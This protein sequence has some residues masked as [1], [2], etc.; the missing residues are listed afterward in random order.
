MPK[1]FLTVTVQHNQNRLTFDFKSLRQLFPNFARRMNPD[2]SCIIAKIF[3]DPIHDGFRCEAEHSIVVEELQN[4]GSPCCHN[5]VKSSH[6]IDFRWFCSQK[7]KPTDDQCHSGS[8]QVPVLLKECH[9]GDAFVK[10]GNGTVGN[11]K[12]AQRFTFFEEPQRFASKC[13]FR[14]GILDVLI[15]SPKLFKQRTHSRGNKDVASE[16]FVAVTR[17]LPIGCA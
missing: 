6:R 7:C 8:N 3:F 10:T 13:S 15:R 17:Q 9:I 16:I 11:A 4:R 2:D 14:G 1:S 5:C 12:A